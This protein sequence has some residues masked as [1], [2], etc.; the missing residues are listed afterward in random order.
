MMRAAF[1]ATGL[2]GVYSAFD[3]A[4]A[5]LDAALDGLWALGFVGVNVTAPHKSAVFARLGSAL[6]PAAARTGAVNT[7]RRTRDGW[8][9]HNTDVEGLV[10]ALAAEAGSIAGAQ[11][12]V[13]GAGGA[14]RA[15]VE[16]LRA[17]G[18]ARVTV[19]ARRV[20]A[21]EALARG[22]MGAGMLVAGA[23]LG[24]TE[25]H[26]A[27]AE[28]GVVLQCTSA[29]VGGRG[30]LEASS[31]TGARG[32]LAADLV[33]APRETP[34]MHDA[35]RAGLRVVPAVGLTMLAAQGAAAFAWW[36]GHPL[37]LAAMRQSLDATPAW[38]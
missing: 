1:A 18:A 27:L 13:L 38:T 22:A 24:S 6:T 16:S 29:E 14:A 28:A 12:V 7:L 15:A 23:G 11:A 31:T 26:G 19:L 25:A 35:A 21:A 32:A 33:Y 5:S 30:R 37:P 20:E 2:D 4:P 36:T 3:V 9:G 10:H 17:L 34:W 8:E